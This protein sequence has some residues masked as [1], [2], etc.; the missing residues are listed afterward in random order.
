[1]R[2]VFAT[3]LISLLLPCRSQTPVSAITS[4]LAGEGNVIRRTTFNGNSLWGYI[5]G[6]ADIYLEYGFDSV[7]VHDINFRGGRIR[8]DLYAMSDPKAAYGIYSVYS[9]S[10]NSK[11]GPG[12]FN[13][14]TRWQLQTVRGRFYLSAILSAGSPEEY[15][16]ALSIANILLADADAGQFEPGDPFRSGAFNSIPGRIKYSRGLLGLENGIPEMAELLKDYKFTD[17]WQITE[18][19]E[20]PGLSATI[21]TFIKDDELL[22]FKENAVFGVPANIQYFTIGGGKVLL[23][24]ESG[25]RTYNYE[26]VLNWLIS[27]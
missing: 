9:L 25:D 10:C 16:Y 15:A 5:N 3:L 22:R 18:I 23:L 20:L 26:K 17:L 7:V 24:L 4:E 13:C 14:G 11:E 1:M 12:H 2:L 21:I 27:Q 8:F 19:P 6:G